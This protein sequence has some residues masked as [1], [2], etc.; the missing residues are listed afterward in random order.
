MV[1]DINTPLN[2]F[3]D[4]VKMNCVYN[5]ISDEIFIIIISNIRDITISHYMKQPPSMLQSKIEKDFIDA[6]DV[7]ARGYFS[8]SFL[9]ICF[10]H[11]R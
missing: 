3:P 7:A 8:F 4:I 5:K 6:Y 1:I 11:L 2:K 9:P 10:R